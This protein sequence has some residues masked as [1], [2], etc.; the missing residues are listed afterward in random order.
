M[1]REEG[2]RTHLAHVKP[3]SFSTP[4]ASTPTASFDRNSTMSTNAPSGHADGDDDVNCCWEQVGI[5]ALVHESC[6]A[7]PTL[8]VSGRAATVMLAP[9][10]GGGG[11]EGGEGGGG[12]EDGGEGDP[13][14]GV[15]RFRSP[16][17]SLPLLPP[18]FPLLLLL[19]PLPPISTG[20][21]AG[22]STHCPFVL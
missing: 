21:G 3:P 7:S 17:L 22:A 15:V 8:I 10:G 12:E 18:L 4:L 14:V 2:E 11:V 1:I 6:T 9:G 5:P 13:G 16:S 19:L 20:L